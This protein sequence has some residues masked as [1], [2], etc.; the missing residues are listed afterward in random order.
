MLEQRTLLVILLNEFELGHTAQTYR[1][2]WLSSQRTVRRWFE[3]VHAE[4]ESL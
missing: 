1:N 3:N 2:V 4:N